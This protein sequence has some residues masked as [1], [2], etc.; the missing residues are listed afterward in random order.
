MSEKAPGEPKLTINLR[1][2]T[3][4]VV[5]LEI[6]GEL[7]RLAEKPL[8]VAYAEATRL[9]AKTIILECSNLTYMNH[10]G[11]SLLVKLLAI[12]QGEKR[13]LFAVGLSDHYRRV[14]RISG[15]DEGIPVVA[16][17]DQVIA[18]A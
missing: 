9:G 15:L 3:D 17:I 10:K 11:V 12:A 1:R 2:V 4:Q 14:F 5:A 8:D 13:R 7:T 18:T 16:D 6:C